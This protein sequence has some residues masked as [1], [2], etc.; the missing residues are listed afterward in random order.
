MTPRLRKFDG[1]LLLRGDEMHEVQGERVDRAAVLLKSPGG[2]NTEIS[3]EE[4][5]LQVAMGNVTTPS[6]QPESNR[7]LDTTGQREKRVRERIL[8]RSK[9]LFQQGF[10]WPVRIEKMKI[11]FSNDP[12]F[13]ARGKPF[14]TARTIQ[15]WEKAVLK[16]GQSALEDRRH[17]SG[18][19]LPRHDS[20]FEEIVYDLLEEQY[21]RSDRKTIAAV[22]RDAR[23]KY[24]DRCR[25]ESRT[26]L[27]H[28]EKVVRSLVQALPHAD[29]VKRRLGPEES[30]KALL[31]AGRFQK[32]QGP[33]ERIEIDSTEADIFVI[34]DAEGNVARPTICAA[35]DCATGFLVGMQI[36]LSKPNGLL[37]AVTLRECMTPTPETFFEK[38]DIRNRHQAYGRFFAA[39]SDQGSENAGPLVEACLLAAQFELRKNIPA[40]PERK[41]FIERFF[42]TM[43]QFLHTLPGATATAELPGS[44]RTKRAMSETCITFDEFSR[45]LQKWRFDVFAKRPQRRIQSALRT[46]ESPTACWKRLSEEHLVPEPPTLREFVRCFSR[47]MLNANCTATESSMKEFNIPPQNSGRSFAK[48]VLTESWRSVLTQLTSASSLL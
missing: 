9:E 35:I 20:L 11:E 38:N 37:T 8:K 2:D 4:F 7:L 16:E 6:G 30:R 19:R 36:T 41:P 23:L 14:P 43:N 40:Q 47:A 1:R 31:Q 15:L 26:P 18:N 48:S 28:G 46:T 32:I 12:E 22:A 39:V 3:L 13:L 5:R 44:K 21:L 45:I 29:V 42:R 33:L 24:L 27:P 25:A 10:T 34:I 17:C